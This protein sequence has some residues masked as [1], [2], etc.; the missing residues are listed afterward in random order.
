MSNL[1]AANPSGRP[2]TVTARLEC[3]ARL[4]FGCWL[5][6]NLASTFAVLCTQ[7]RCSRVFGQTSPAAF[8]N[9]SAL[10]RW[11]A[12]A[13]RRARAE[14]FTFL[15]SRHRGFA[16]VDFQAELAGQESAD[17][18]PHPFAGMVAAN[19]DV[20]V[21]RVTAEPDK[22]EHAFIGYPCGYARHQDVLF[23]LVGKSFQ[24]E[25]N[26]Y[27]VAV[28]DVTLCLGCS[29]VGGPA[30]AE[31]RNCAPKTSDPIALGELSNGLLN[32]AST[33]WGSRVSWLRHPASG[34]RPA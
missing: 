34:F 22:L 25:I 27:V 15:G 19:I 26:H 6:G 9:P 7:Q 4:A 24:I 11:R 31:I 33:T 16:I 28:S 20:A 21:I 5:F 1:T 13:A 32:Q 8:Q 30:S 2:S 18:G 10:R 3:K 14:K 12:A 23:N 29:L 17:R